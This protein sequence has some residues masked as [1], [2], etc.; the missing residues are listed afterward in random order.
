MN[1]SISKKEMMIS[2]FIA[3]TLIM[4]MVTS[5]LIL[6]DREII[7]PEIAAMAIAMWAYREPGWIRQPSTIF[8]APSI[9]AILGF[10]V[11]HLTIGY[12]EKVIITLVLIMLFFRLFKS[13]LAPA[14]ATGLLPLVMNANEWTF[15]ISVIVLTL[16]LM[17][18]VLLFGLHKGLDQKVKTEYKYMLV[19]LVLNLLWIGLCWLFGYPRLAVIP[20][21]LVV[22][23]ETLQKPMY[24]EKMAFKQGLVLTIS[25]T[26]GT[27][28]YL[29]IDSWILV[30]LLD[31]VLMIVLLRLV[32]IRMPAVFAFPLLPFVFPEEIVSVLPL[33]TLA[34]SIFLFGSVLAYKKFE[35]KQR[36]NVMQ[37]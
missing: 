17:L 9:T 35:M 16:I 15:I 11:N 24:N 26:V 34:A 23:Y 25:A 32:G 33:G 7:L 37:V 3:I 30:T 36:G 31:M 1:R 22:V 29:A 2:Y 20:P 4:V 19:F 28:L 18:G 21:I 12:L 8:L 13:S 5:S 6:K 10:A 27:L 14:I